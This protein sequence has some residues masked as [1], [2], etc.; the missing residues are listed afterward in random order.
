MSAP[1]SRLVIGIWKAGL[2][3]EAQLCL[4]ITHED[5]SLGYCGRAGKAQKARKESRNTGL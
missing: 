4:G 3:D 1:R 5:S 2:S